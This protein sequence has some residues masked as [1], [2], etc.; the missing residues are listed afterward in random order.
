MQ[1]FM[2]CLS[3][4]VP[5]EPAEYLKVT[6]VVNHFVMLV[7]S[8]VMV[9]K[10]RAIKGTGNILKGLAKRLRP[11]SSLTRVPRIFPAWE[12]GMSP[13]QNSPCLYAT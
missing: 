11:F 4:L 5:Y 2:K 3:D 13:F 1:F 7:I 6:M 8:T 9:F 12:H 10:G